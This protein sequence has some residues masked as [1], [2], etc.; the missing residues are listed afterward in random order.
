[1]SYSLCIWE[2]VGF[3][4]FG[5]H[6]T[7][8]IRYDEKKT[9]EEMEKEKEEKKKKKTRRS[10][11]S[12]VALYCRVVTTIKRNSLSLLL[13]L[14]LRLRLRL[15]RLLFSLPLFFNLSASPLVYVW[16]RPI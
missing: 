11:L 1:M 2:W 12:C 15:L 7:T 10:R 9:D 16:W 13:L 6:R 3:T 5:L 14:R 4:C 8:T